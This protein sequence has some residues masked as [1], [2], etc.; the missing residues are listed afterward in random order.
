MELYDDLVVTIPAFKHYD[1][2]G[3]EH[4]VDIGI[5]PLGTIGSW[6]NELSGSKDDND[7]LILQICNY[8][9][10]IYTTAGDFK[11]DV[12][13]DFQVYL[14]WSLYY[15]SIERIKHLLLPEILADGR[16]Y[17]Q[18]IDGAHFRDF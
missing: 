14:F 5:S 6:L 8:L 10:H 17:L 3:R 9:N 1:L 16:V 7:Q 18:T 12:R 11:Q 4:Y 2:F 15:S 13:N